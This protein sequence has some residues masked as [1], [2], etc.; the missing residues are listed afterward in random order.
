MLDRL[1]AST[2]GW[3]L[4]LGCFLLAVCGA[5]LLLLLK[6]QKSLSV[7]LKNQAE[8]AAQKSSAQAE[9]LEE[10][11]R[12][13][14]ARQQQAYTAV[15]TESSRATAQHMDMLSTRLD[16]FD[17]SQDIRLHRISS[18][19]D[20]KL[21]QNDQ[22]AEQ[23]K[24]SLNTGMEK[25]RRENA[26]K[27]EQMRQTV[28]EKLHETLNKRLGESF[29]LVNERLEQ[30]YK[31]LGEMHSLA[32]G[33]GDLKKVLSNVK[34]RGIW[35]EVQLGA[36]LSQILAPAQYAEN[37]QVI[38]H[39]SERVEYAVILPGAEKDSQI[40]LP[41]DSKYPMEAY[42]RLLAAAE[43]G[44]PETVSA[45]STAL[46]GAVRTEAK[47]ISQKYIEP[48]YTTDFAVMFLAT[49][50]LY[51]EALRSRGLMEELQQKYRILIAGPSTL[52]ALLNS[53]QVG[54]RTLAI[55]QRSAEVW[56]LL[57]AVKTEFARFSDLLDQTQQRLRQAGETIEKAAVRTRAINRRLRDVEAIGTGQTENLLSPD[58]SD[59]HES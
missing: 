12:N 25:L 40:Y 51:A 27:L 28:D 59:H 46:C 54:F 35:G 14:L 4:A 33:V 22:R 5:L 29:S 9:T 13:E 50:G 42:E 36:L 10:H 21:S 39:S 19:L 57:G 8:Q 6:R 44:D 31:G 18:T 41:I 23:L 55:E 2:G 7:Q 11:M 45:A 17:Q 47:R 16:V 37:V 58:I 1:S 32:N 26:E 34:T 48:P 15:L 30:V 43:S 3:L 53:L 56:Q 20:S 24:D 52:S 49:E 38:P